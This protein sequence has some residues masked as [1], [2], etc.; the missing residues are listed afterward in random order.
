MRIAEA[1]GIKACHVDFPDL[2]L[3]SQWLSD[4]EPCLI[5][6]HLP[7]DCRLI[8]K[9]NWNSKEIQPPIEDDVAAKIRTIF[10]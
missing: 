6:I 7:E 4:P 10:S 1:Y 3:Y 8:P 2:E 5:D 9:V